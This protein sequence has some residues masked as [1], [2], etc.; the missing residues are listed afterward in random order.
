MYQG[1]NVENLMSNIIWRVVLSAVYAYN[2]CLRR[3]T[4]A[5]KSSTMT[6]TKSCSARCRCRT[7]GGSCST[8]SIRKA[9]A[10]FR[11]TFSKPPSTA[12]TSCRWSRPGS[13]SSCKIDW[14][15]FDFFA[16][17][18]GLD[19][20]AVNVVRQEGKCLGS[21]NLNWLASPKI[22]IVSVTFVAPQND[23]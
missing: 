10:K 16:S 20:L 17:F 1:I 7:S 2:R 12:E 15:R 11:S 6:T 21:L 3:M 5:P 14:N 4:T 8:S 23:P 9:S 18:W 13:W 19:W 22:S